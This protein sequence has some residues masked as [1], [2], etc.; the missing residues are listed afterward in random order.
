VQ[1]G[2]GSRASLTVRSLRTAAAVAT[3]P[4]PRPGLRFTDVTSGDG[5][6]FVAVLSR[7]DVCRS[8]LYKFRLGDAGHLTALTALPGTGR[9][10][11][12]A[13]L[14]KDSTTLALATRPCG[15]GARAH[16]A[17][18]A[19][20]NLATRQ[21]SQWRLPGAGHVSSLSLNASGSLLAYTFDGGPGR[22]ALYVL[23][24]KFQAPAGSAQRGPVLPSERA[25]A[26]GDIRTAVITPDGSTVYFITDPTGKASARRWQLHAVSLAT[27][28][29]R[30]V[31]SYAGIPGSLA[32]DPSVTRV[33]VVIRSAHRPT[34]SA[35]PSPARSSAG[36][37]RPAPAPSRSASKSRALAGLL[38]SA[39]GSWH[40]R[41]S[42]PTP[43]AS[44]SRQPAPS[45]SRHR[46]PQRTPSP[47]PSGRRTP[48]PTPSPS[49]SRHPTPGPT[50]SPSR[51]PTPGPTPSPSPSRGP[52]SS[53][54]ALIT[55]G[56]GAPRFLR[57]PAWA[58]QATL[59]Y[60][61]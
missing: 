48:Q 5:R 28:H 6:T 18:L 41:T 29:T 9:S 45:P 37:R 38:E 55:L 43:S 42:Q 50:P 8:W 60:C 12:K 54:L 13:A 52:G 61:W 31:G 11:E 36:S 46:T 17:E 30:I 32:A 4:A 14:S 49:P 58:P 51:H 10:V 59:A 27:G 40:H 57:A 23:D 3:I 34:P 44:P 47:S 24:T 35:S 20:V 22:E 26:R 25:S 16:P 21:A 39:A 19:E 7:A 33:L 15:Q 53:R 56:S 2:S 1:L